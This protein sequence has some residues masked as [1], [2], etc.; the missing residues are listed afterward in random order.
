[1]PETDIA[2]D[3][4]KAGDFRDTSIEAVRS[5]ANGDNVH[6][7]QSLI[8]DTFGNPEATQIAFSHVDVD[9]CTSV[10]AFL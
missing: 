5:L 10:R 4:H 3:P 8:P 2:R 1:M 9:I 7:H 6:F